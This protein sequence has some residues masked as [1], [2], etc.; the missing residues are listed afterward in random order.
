MTFVHIVLNPKHLGS[1]R[2]RKI[3]TSDLLPRTS[4]DIV[5]VLGENRSI[6]RGLVFVLA[7]GDCVLETSGKRGPCR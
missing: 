4:I 1:A 2:H 5:V 3:H 7:M 6:V